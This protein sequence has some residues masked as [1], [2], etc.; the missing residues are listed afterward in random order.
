[1]EPEFKEH[2]LILFESIRGKLVNLIAEV[3]KAIEQVHRIDKIQEELWRKK[4]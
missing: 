1:M 3:D 4:Q 2:Y